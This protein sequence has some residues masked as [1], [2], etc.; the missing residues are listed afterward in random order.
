MAEAALPAAPAGA[1]V[2]VVDR[3][4]EMKEINALVAQNAGALPELLGL[5][6]TPE[7]NS[8]PATTAPPK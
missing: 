7:P 4:A 6:S 5:I 3:G 1:P 2:T 8:A